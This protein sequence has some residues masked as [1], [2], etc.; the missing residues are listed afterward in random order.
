LFVLF[1]FGLPAGHHKPAVK[2]ATMPFPAAANG[3]NPFRGRLPNRMVF[4]VFTGSSSP[5][6]GALQS[7]PAGP[8]I[9]GDT[10][11]NRRDA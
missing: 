8:L 11:A 4:P 10:I 3:K 6:G 5:A 1:D 9:R 2:I 7:R